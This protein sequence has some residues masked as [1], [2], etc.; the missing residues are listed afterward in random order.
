MLDTWLQHLCL[1]VL[2]IKYTNQQEK[3]FQQ[4]STWLNYLYQI[5][6]YVHR[7]KLRGEKLWNESNL[8]QVRQNVSEVRT[9][10]SI[11]NDTTNVSLQQT[12]LEGG[13]YLPEVLQF[14]NNN[15]ME[16]K[17]Y[18]VLCS[19]QNQRFNFSLMQSEWVNFNFSSNS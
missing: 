2:Y 16:F 15:R 17:K 18:H 6:F 1:T 10:L 7:N 9:I 3:R 5:I 14:T 12:E 19:W 8:K 4:K 11:Y 13:I